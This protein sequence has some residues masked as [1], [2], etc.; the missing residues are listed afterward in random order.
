MAKLT[1]AQRDALV[2]EVVSAHR[3][4]DPRGALI[5]SPAFHDLDDEDRMRA[6]EASIAARTLEAALDPGGR[7][8]TVRA[9]LKILS[10]S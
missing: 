4:I 9:V 10:R 2:E 3:A 1:Q 5:P 8:T 7:S 6:F